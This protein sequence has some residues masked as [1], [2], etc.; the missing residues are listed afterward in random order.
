MTMGMTP[1]SST[2]ARTYIYFFIYFLPKACAAEEGKRCGGLHW[3][4]APVRS[5]K[6]GERLDKLSGALIRIGAFW[7][8]NPVSGLD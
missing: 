6:D 2:P 4:A 1:S 8:T 5:Q 7:S 3:A